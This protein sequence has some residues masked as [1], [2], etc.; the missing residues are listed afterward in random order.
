M[1]ASISALTLVAV[2]AIALLL[3]VF[4]LVVWRAQRADRAPLWLAAWLAASFVFAFCRLLQFVPLSDSLY[5]ILPRIIMT[6]SYS[7]AWLGYEFANTFAG[8]RPKRGERVLFITLVA[9]PVILLWVTNF[10]WTEEVVVRA[11]PYGGMAHGAATGPLFIP[12]NLLILI[13]GIIPALRLFLAKSI[14][15]RENWLMGLGLLAVVLFNVNDII[16]IYLNADWIR[17]S[18]YS[19]LPLAIFFSFVQLKRFGLLYRD[20]SV[21]VRARTVELSQ[22]NETLRASE[23]KFAN[24]FRISPDSIN[25]NRLSDGLYLEI[26]DGFTALTG[27]TAED[28]KGRTSGDLDIWADTADRD[29]LVQGLRENGEVTNLEASFRLKDGRI[30]VGLMSARMIQIG[31]ETCILSITR[32]ISEI[33]QA[34]EEIRHQADEMTALYETTHDLVIERDLSKL[35]HTIVERA[36]GLLHASGGGLYLS[37]P[38]QRQVR[39]VVSYHTPRD[40]TNTVLKYG[41][42]AA[43]IVAESGEPLIIDDYRAWLGRAAT[44]EEEQPFV[45]VLSVPMRWQQQ[46]I[47]VIHILEATQTRAFK[48]EDLRVLT[49]F[50]NQAAIA[51][52]NARL[53]SD[54][55]GVL[56]VQ[57]KL[58]GATTSITSQMDLGIILEN[59]VQIVQDAI[60]ADQ[61]NVMLIDERGY[62]YNW[63]GLG[64]SYD[65]QPHFVRP[66]GISMQVMRSG[67]ARFMPDM[68]NTPDANKLMVED[69]I[70]SSS[71]LPLRGKSGTF[72]VMWVN[73]LTPHS[74]S[75]KDQEALEIF[76]SQAAIAIE[77]A[78]LFEFEQRR[79]QEAA[80]IAEVGRD[81]SASL[82]LDV[83]LERIASHAKEL[84]HGETS[85][86]YLIEPSGLTLRA[87][88]ALGPDSEEIK[89]DPITLGEG[90]LGA[91]VLRN[92]GEIVNDTASDVRAIT[93]KGTEDIPIEHLIGVPILSRDQLTG[94]I[95]V[96]RVGEGQDFAT[97]DKDFLTS[98]AQQVAIA[99]ENARLFAAER[100]RRQEAE[101][102]REATQMISS[103]LDQT[104]AIQTIL[105][106]LAKVVPYD[107]ASVQLLRE[108][109]LEIVGGRGW[110]DPAAV[111]GMRFPVP[112]KNPNTLVV[113]E[114]RPVNVRDAAKEFKPFRHHPHKYIQSWLGVPLIVRGRV[115]GMFAVDHRQP[116]FFTDADVQMVNA[117]A[118]QAAVAIE[119]ARL[120]EETRRRLAELEIIQ[121]IAS[122]LRIAQS[123]DEVFP[124]VLDQLINLL[125]MDSAL[126]DLIDPSSGEIVSVMARGLWTP[127]VGLRTPDTVGGSGRVI[128]TG[129]PYV[130]TTA[131]ADGLVARPDMLA[132]VDDVAC[133][134]IVAQ[135][136]PIGTLWV[137][138][139]SH[140]PLTGEE[141]N[142]LSALGEMVGNTIQRM[143]LHEQT[144]NQAE[145]IALAYDL[146]LE[147]WAKALELR[148]KETE[149]HSRR[150]S[151]LTLQ[152]AMQFNIA[153][154][155]LTHIRRGVLLHDIGKMGVPDQI[156][157]KAGPLSEEEWSE[158][159]KHPQYAYDLIYPIDYLR[160]AL[161][162]PYCHHERWDGTGYPR[163]LQGEQIPLAARIFAVVDV[164]DALSTDRPYR[165]AWPKPF[166]L[167]Y[168]HQQSGKH[169]DPKVVE[170]F[171]QSPFD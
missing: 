151:D 73:F 84:L 99:I 33:K 19:Y 12:L 119:N 163:G 138:R 160:P 28:V 25:I 146:T 56:S 121:T 6:A 110:P 128:A 15:R 94:L 101:T 34:Q 90:I 139:H 93:I 169:F 60:G 62:C 158:M 148:D 126:V 42:G 79:R 88:A 136:Q 145:E 114:R 124:I 7:L 46:V 147:G 14:Y 4:C 5:I 133:I 122:A 40:Y 95:A 35:L 48:Q 81:I 2:L 153:E 77:N 31:G 65:L 111:M 149:G 11:I 164:Y 53:F 20:M 96:W 57:S 92:V 55:Q 21:M 132:G 1:T 27:Y 24:A 71:C 106:Q 97:A 166:V 39:C 156:L 63:L 30:K 51:V 117:M 134:P 41:E 74:F 43:G 155:E 86:V 168:L 137:G 45:S 10:I 52:A 47:G 103:T 75:P 50:A 76:A 112:G 58:F 16:A 18:D 171:F 167:D 118:G 115:I 131:K 161:D 123:P 107:S 127:Y 100:N 105:D 9:I 109:Y 37:E 125:D 44:F 140:R 141:V 108:G 85:A 32:D 91:I 165:A 23:H 29:G 120:F 116:N 54:L 152:M 102:L 38:E 22:T 69:G 3:I 26:N 83:V 159:R 82:Q 130:T 68:G 64:Y 129:I 157:K 104:Q 162:I 66:N 17:L 72:G 70:Q 144:V 150:V 13:L 170:V 67:E 143:K 59:I 8:L 98:L 135:R 80:A 113:Q 36:T 142:L 87:I 78:H 49:L 89:D 61:A 154:H